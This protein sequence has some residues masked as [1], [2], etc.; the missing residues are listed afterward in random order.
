M[1]LTNSTNTQPLCGTPLGSKLR[2]D[3]TKNTFP[4]G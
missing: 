2:L 1:L 4:G 3:P